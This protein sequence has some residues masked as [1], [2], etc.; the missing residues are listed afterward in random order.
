MAL[1][2]P[3]LLGIM[4]GLAGY[5]L[6]RNLYLP[7]LTETGQSDGSFELITSN[8][9]RQGYLWVVPFSKKRA[10]LSHCSTPPPHSLN[11]IL[12]LGIPVAALCIHMS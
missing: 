8:V 1:R 6:F 5:M 11:C 3:V 9:S 2:G 7:S 10:S 12:C 4:G